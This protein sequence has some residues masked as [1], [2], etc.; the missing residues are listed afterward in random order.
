MTLKLSNR[1]TIPTFKVLDILQ[2]VNAR[3][4]AGEDIIHL[5]AGQPSDGAPQAAIDHAISILKKEPGQGY[6]EAVGKPMLRE[7]IARF[8]KER[9]GITVDPSQIIITVGASGG[10]LFTFL[11]CFEHG[12]RVALAAPGYGAYRNILKTLGLEA[13]EIEATAEEDYQPT[14]EKL[15]ALD[16]KPDGLIVAS[17][18]NPAGTVLSP[19]KLKAICDWCAANNVRVI[20]DEIYHGVTF[21]DPA[22]TVLRFNQ[23]AVVV[24]SFSKYFAMTGWRLGW[25]VVPKEA[26]P[27]F[28]C[29]AE[30]LFVAPPTLS[31]YV[32]AA[33]FD[34]CDVLDSY[35]A[36]YKANFE[37]LREELPKAGFTKISDTKGAFYLYAD[38]S[39][40]TDDSEALCRDL[41]DQAGVAMTPGT[42]FDLTRG[43]QAVRMSFAGSTD[44]I[45]NACRRLQA[46]W[47]RGGA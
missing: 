30:S 35:V 8:Y 22:E 47:Q 45:R 19:Q 17:P 7:R 24:Q 6:T 12:D 42:D 13:V 31:Q 5:E 38:V 15:A 4:V 16:P 33:A 25:L 21:E 43:H 2:A 46:W 44:D 34:H 40:L 3:V 1:S 18:S 29:L 11:A 9:Y 36:R 37:V 41:I 10:F 14:V 32:A 26:A 28:K 39:D 27:R 23:D 20:A